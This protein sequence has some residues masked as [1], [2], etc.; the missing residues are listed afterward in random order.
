M[1]NLKNFFNTFLEAIEYD[2]NNDD[3]IKKF[4]SVVYAQAV[5]SLINGLS[6]EKKEEILESLSLIT[7]GSVLHITLNDFFGEETLLETLNNSAQSVLREYL[8]AIYASLTEEQRFR[9]E[10]IF[11]VD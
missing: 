5:S 8:A 3:F 2:G 7:D 1:E 9:V 10:N 11:V 4:T 6:K